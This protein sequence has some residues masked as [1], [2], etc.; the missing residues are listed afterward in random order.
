MLQTRTTS[1]LKDRLPDD[2]TADLL[3]L[4][5]SVLTLVAAILLGL[6]RVG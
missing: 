6:A 3:R 1:T 5:A 4:G 2:L